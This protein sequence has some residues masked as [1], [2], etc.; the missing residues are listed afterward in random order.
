MHRARKKIFL[1]FRLPT[2]TADAADANSFLFIRITEIR[3]GPHARH[4]LFQFIR[5]GPAPF[6]QTGPAH[7]IRTGPALFIQTGPVHFMHTGPALFYA[8]RTYSFKAPSHRSLREMNSAFVFVLARSS[9]TC[10][11][12]NLPEAILRSA[13]AQRTSCSLWKYSA[14]LVKECE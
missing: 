12:P 3:F 4:R 14:R 9:R 1:F 2:P 5:E 8:H 6:I 10:T 13:R 11:A 7:F